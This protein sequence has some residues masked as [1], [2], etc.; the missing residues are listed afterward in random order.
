MTIY[1]DT[2]QPWQE[3]IENM[4]V[5]RILVKAIVRSRF[6][7]C[8]G[9][10]AISLLHYNFAF[11]FFVPWGI[12]GRPSSRVEKRRIPSEGRTAAR[13]AMPLN[14]TAVGRAENQEKAVEGGSVGVDRR[15]GGATDERRRER[16]RRNGMNVSDNDGAKEVA[17]LFCCFSSFFVNVEIT[18][19]GLLSKGIS[20]L[21]LR[22]KFSLATPSLDGSALYMAIIS[23]DRSHGR[24]SSLRYEKE[25]GRDNWVTTSLVP[26]T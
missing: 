1:H 10:F 23:A 21:G 18:R 12:A 11:C 20:Y 26:S 16:G 22:L 3:M 25:R 24:E 17:P 4:V 9:L 13:P 19:N 15:V 2:N 7:Q 14:L 8:L 5:I 6:M